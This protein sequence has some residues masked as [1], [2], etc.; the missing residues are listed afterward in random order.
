VA[1]H[2]FALGDVEVAGQLLAIESVVVGHEVD[3]SS[4]PV[5]ARCGDAIDLGAV[6]RRE[7]DRLVDRWRGGEQRQSV[8]LAVGREG[9]LLSDLYWRGL[10]AQTHK[11]EMHSL[12]ARLFTYSDIGAPSPERCVLFRQAGPAR[13]MIHNL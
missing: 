11:C 10:M 3:D 5:G 8:F 7:D 13:A 2:R 12:A 4:G 1:N 9:Q 6:A